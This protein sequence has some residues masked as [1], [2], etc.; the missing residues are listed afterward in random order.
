[1]GRWGPL[2][3]FSVPGS[4]GKF[5]SSQQDPL[6]PGLGSTGHSHLVISQ[7]LVETCCAPCCLT[8]GRLCVCA[9]GCWRL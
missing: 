5:L 6:P 2:E 3:D 9:D 1:M 7:L 4:N 8:S